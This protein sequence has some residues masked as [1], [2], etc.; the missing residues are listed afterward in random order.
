[1]PEHYNARLVQEAAPRE[2][3]GRV[4]SV[5]KAHKTG[6]MS[7]ERSRGRPKG[8]KNKPKAL[9][10]A[11]VANDLLGVVKDI[12]PQEY[13][14]EMKDAIKTGKN[15]STINEA[16]ILM[17]LMG[18]PLWQRLIEESKP[19][20]VLPAGMD[21]DLADEIGS[22]VPVESSSK[23]TNERMKIMISLM[24]LVS[25][26][27]QDEQ[28]TDNSEKPILEITARRGLD[29]ERI[30][31][32]IGFESGSVG[33]DTDGT[34]RAEP[35]IRAIPSELPSRPIDVSDSEQ[36]QT[37]RVLNDTSDRDLPLSDDES[38]L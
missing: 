18:P 38:E 33:G 34:G 19:R 17:K 16:K 1:M 8:S 30:K 27:E 10:P 2:T 25:R 9:L 31:F 4:S 23:E 28:G 14:Q 21:S 5:A 6:E 13:Y 35:D 20:D 37:V 29:S 36:V 22:V 3:E 15:I 11:E 26:L 24:Q 12:L 7:S 32:L